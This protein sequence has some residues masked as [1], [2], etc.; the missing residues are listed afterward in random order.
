MNTYI[1]RSAILNCQ[2][3]LNTN[4]KILWSIVN[5]SDISIENNHRFNYLDKNHYQLKIQRIE[6]YDNDLVFECYYEN[7][8]SLS[9]CL[10]QLH[11]EKF[12]PPPILIYVPNNQT[13]PNGVEV[14][15][16]CQTKDKT[17]IQWWFIPTNHPHKLI[18][19]ETNKKYRIENNHDLI[20]RHAEK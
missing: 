11:I 7:K 3:P 4:E 14:L 20:I 10:I 15:F 13:V 9:Q 2:L 8:K 5:R 18:K 17:K 6:E 16:P 19:I 1:G 12:E